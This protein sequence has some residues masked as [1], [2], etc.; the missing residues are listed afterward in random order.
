MGRDATELPPRRVTHGG[1]DR[2]LGYFVDEGVAAAAYNWAAAALRGDKAILNPL[3]APAD[4]DEAGPS[5]PR[6]SAALPPASQPAGECSICLGSLDQ[7]A[8]FEGLPLD[9]SEAT[10]SLECSHVFHRAC[11]E[12]W[13][14]RQ[15]T[16]PLCRAAPR[17]AARR[18]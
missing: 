9:A 7:S 11:L 14:E 4:A 16:C 8:G 10:T 5:S 17:R 3:P 6:L 12:L 15:R 13:F 18:S 2:H 1:K